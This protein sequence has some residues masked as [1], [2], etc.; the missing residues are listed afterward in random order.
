MCV[1]CVTFCGRMLSFWLSIS[2]CVVLL[3]VLSTFGQASML[4]SLTSEDIDEM[5]DADLLNVLELMAY[6]VD[7][8]G[9][10][11]QEREDEDIATSDDVENTDTEEEWASMF[12]I[13]K[14]KPESGFSMLGKTLTRDDFTSGRLAEYL[15]SSAIELMDIDDTYRKEGMNTVLKQFNE[16]FDDY[17]SRNSNTLSENVR[18]DNIIKIRKAFE[19]TMDKSPLTASRRTKLAVASKTITTSS[20]PTGDGTDKVEVNSQKQ[21]YVEKGGEKKQHD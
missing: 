19:G 4:D 8:D 6:E 10:E 21:T 3:S 15:I 13:F 9:L 20:T 1:H 11:G 12:E 17:N 2:I 14:K 16:R 5:Q 7:D 18:S